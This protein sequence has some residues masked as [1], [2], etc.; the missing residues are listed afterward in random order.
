MYD[1]DFAY[2]CVGLVLPLLLARSCWPQFLP[3]RIGYLLFGGSVGSVA[4]AW[5]SVFFFYLT[6][7]GNFLVPQ[8]FLPIP[9]SS[10]GRSVAAA[11]VVLLVVIFS[12]SHI[13]PSLIIITDPSAALK[14]SEY[15]I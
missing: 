13:T 2:L 1:T 7:D 14:I 9:I 10:R 4:V 3:S 12:N 15:S 5:P 8:T 11:A 6:E